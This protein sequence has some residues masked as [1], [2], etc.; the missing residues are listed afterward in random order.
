MVEHIANPRELFGATDALRR[1]GERIGLVPTMGALHSGHLSLIDAVRAAGATS[2]VVSIFV[3][4]L[5]FGPNE[6]LAKYPRTFADDVARCE[7][8]G[9]DIVYAPTPDLMYPPGFQ[10]HVEV[11]RLTLEHDGPRRPGHFRGVATVVT[12]LFTAA[13]P[14]IAAFGRKDYQQL[15]TV[16][17][18][19]RDL[20]LPVT[21]LECPT[22]REHDG[23]AL[24]SRNRYLTPD[25]RVRAVAMYRG[26]H[27]ASVA[28]N[29]GERSV[30]TLL[31]AAHEPIAHAFDSI[32][33][34]TVANASDLTTAQNEAPH[35][36]VLLVAARI[37][38]TRLID[39]CLLGEECLDP[40]NSP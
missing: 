4:P 9:V 40:H 11:E 25:Q 15:R 36:S 26:L 31:Q 22:Q 32:D 21:I 37:G 20:D 30:T 1:H 29:R 6:D 18:L 3:N 28:F 38:A 2:I 27:A 7:E 33:Y 8:H 17:Q 39:N 10:T 23:L 14:C 19:V 24:S 12:K 34:L 5:Q 35:A 16:H 13:G